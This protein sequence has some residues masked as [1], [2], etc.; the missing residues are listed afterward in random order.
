M[1]TE[2]S[3]NF[4]RN[5]L[6]R[7]K[8]LYHTYQCNIAVQFFDEANRQKINIDQEKLMTISRNAA[9]NFLDLFIE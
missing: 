1:T 8:D 4:L 9:K 7:D 6:K 2:E 3:V 5:K